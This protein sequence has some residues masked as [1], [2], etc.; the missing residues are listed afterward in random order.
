MSRRPGRLVRYVLLLGAALGQAACG[1][2][3]SAHPTTPGNHAPTATGGAAAVHGGTGVSPSLRVPWVE[4]PDLWDGHTFQ[5]VT[6]PP[7]G[8]VAI[9]P[10]GTGWT[11][12]PDGVTSALLSF[13]YRVFDPA[14]ASTLGTG[15]VRV[16][17]DAALAS[18]LARGAVNGDGTIASYG[19]ANACTY[20]STYQTRRTATG[21]TVTV[22][23]FANRPSDGSSPKA[24]VVLIGGGNLDMGLAGGPGG[25]AATA[26]GGNYVIRT[27][28]RLADAGYATMALDRPSDVTAT[29]ADAYRISPRHAVDLLQLLRRSNTRELDVFLVGTS[30][31]ALSVVAQNRLASGVAVSSPVTAQGASTSPYF[32]GAAQSEPRL[33][34]DWVE[35]P[36]HVMWHDAD[37]CTSLSPPSGAAALADALGASTTVVAGGFQ[38]TQAARGVTPDVCGAFD[39]H[40]FLGV[41]PEAVAA[42]V[43]WL[44]A[45]VAALA[46]NRRP[47]VV[48]ATA[49]TAAAAP[50]TVDLST[51][52]RDPEGDPLTFEL[53]FETSALGGTVTLAG[54]ALTYTP[55]SLP[56]GVAAATDDVVWVVRDDHGH[57][58]AAVLSVQVGG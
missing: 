20:Y 49:S 28:Q 14:G 58:A 11:F 45:R 18:C 24:Y 5:L 25:V 38:V 27:A 54:H 10:D 34:P 22:D 51:F 29:G 12:A 4:D 16:Y 53:P 36:S 52:A 48:F 17:D 47:R 6:T 30:R 39:H 3:T 40:G 41:E 55:P 31:G 9:T 43:A 32:V 2:S 44:D 15:R 56:S 21:A 33:R 37:A 26:G 46:G 8:T 42:T 23:G 1:G 7:R 57:V 13:T 50:V 35:R 19:K